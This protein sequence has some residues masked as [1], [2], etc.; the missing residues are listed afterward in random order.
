MRVLADRLRQ[1]RRPGDDRG[2]VLVELMLVV[3]F[4][5][6]VMLGV[7][8]IGLLWRAQMTESN[9]VRSGVRVGS[10]AGKTV[11][12]DYSLLSAVGSGLGSLQG[13]GT[14]NWVVVYRIDGANTNVPA[15]CITP[16][17]LA[18]GGNAGLHCNTYDGADLADVV[19]NPVSAQGSFGDTSCLTGKDRLWCPSSR[20]VDQDV[21]TGP[22]LLGVAVSI[23]YQTF[24]KITSPTLNLTDHAVMRLEPTGALG[25]LSGP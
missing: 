25:A 22:D 24:T 15:G 17:A 6:F 19:T 8:E 21:G 20:N 18:A 14:V 12:A 4:I 2:V 23:T 1:R 9:A 16:S 13:R 10:N 11:L 3:P 5:M 7:F